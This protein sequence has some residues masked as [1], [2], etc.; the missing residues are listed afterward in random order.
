MFY[1]LK[2]T[3]T[4]T[5]MDEVVFND[6]EEAIFHNALQHLL[7]LPQVSWS[8]RELAAYHAK[9]YIFHVTE[10]RSRANLGD[11]RGSMTVRMNPLA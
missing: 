6:L 10:R 8:D 3:K 9:Q 11:Q 5:A 4:A 1:A 2:P 7:V